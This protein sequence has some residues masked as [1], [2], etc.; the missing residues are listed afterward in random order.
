MPEITARDL[1]RLEALEGRLSKAQ[2]ERK[3][4]EEERRGLRTAVV[5][6]A[7]A[8]READRRAAAVGDK[9]EAVLAENQKLAAR[10][11]E[12]AADLE[13]LKS[14]AAELRQKADG[15]QGQLAASQEQLANTE[16]ALQ[17]V[18][19]ERDQLAEKVQI[20]EDQ[21]AEKGM[22]QV[23]PPK[24]VGLLVGGLV[25]EVSAQL[26]G[27]SVRDGEIRLQVAFAKVGK[28][29]GFVVPSAEAPEEIRQ[30]LHE[31]AIRFDR[32]IELPG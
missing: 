17:G 7:R 22:P 3:A 23:L 26:P 5:A 19:S 25:D 18:T 27:M 10:L 24:D 4:L 29:S 13:R 16:R 6:N 28:A 1:R 30:N 9:L 11:E 21:L 14:A 12:M 31:V 8:A 2:S 20:A 32:S 15:A